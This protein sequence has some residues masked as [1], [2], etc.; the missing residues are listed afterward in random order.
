M[1]SLI[2]SVGEGGRN[3]RSDVRLV[4]RLLNQHSLPPLRALKVDGIV[5][6]NTIDSKRLL[7]DPGDGLLQMTVGRHKTLSRTALHLMGGWQAVRI[8]FKKSPVPGPY[9]DRPVAGH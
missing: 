8:T 3:R 5:G 6:S 4:Q 7:P 1:P 2:E 9:G